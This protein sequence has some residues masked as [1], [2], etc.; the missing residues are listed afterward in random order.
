MLD[1][2][3]CPFVW[4][5]DMRG[6]LLEVNLTPLKG[7]KVVKGRTACGNKLKLLKH[8]KR[9]HFHVRATVRPVP[10]SSEGVG[11]VLRVQVVPG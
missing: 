2:L 11:P 8:F 6:V 3:K 10:Q 7:W 1:R 5:S 9:R 4:V